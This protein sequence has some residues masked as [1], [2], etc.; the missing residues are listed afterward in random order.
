MIRIEHLSVRFRDFHLGTIDLVLEEG[1]FFVLMGPTGAGKTVLL[2]SIAGLVP[3]DSGTIRIA[4]V[5]VTRMPPERRGVG[6]VYQDQGLFPH[7]DVRSNIVYGLK[8]CGAG[9]KEGQKRLDRLI[10]LL[11]IAHLLRRLPV[12]L[13]GGEKQRV[14]LARALIVEPHV[15]LLDEPL[16]AIDP[17]FRE[18]LRRAL[19]RLHWASGTTFLMVTHDFGEALTLADRGA[20]LHRGAVE[21]AGPIEEIFRA[22]ASLAVAE[23]VGM[24]NFFLATVENGHARLARRRDSVAPSGGNPYRQ[25]AIRPEDL[26]VSRTAPSPKNACTYRGTVSAVVG[27]GFGHEVYVRAEDLTFTARMT[28]RALMEEQICEGAN[29]FISFDPVVLHVW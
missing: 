11:G 26:V 8:F 9:Q 7:M 18:D 10:D 4:G 1:E 6:I 22:P 15:L 28:R 23:F 21:Q 13:S 17:G 24:K 25:A 27:C 3:L 20:V 16:S 29:V 14:A 2:E 5:D 19:K 12:N